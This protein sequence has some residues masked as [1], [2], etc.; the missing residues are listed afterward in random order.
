MSATLGQYGMNRSIAE[1]E[2]SR[3]QLRSPKYRTRDVES[4]RVVGPLGLLLVAC[5]A[6][7]STA[8]SPIQR[9]TQLQDSPSPSHVD[10]TPATAAPRDLSA[11]RQQLA[12]DIQRIEQQLAQAGDTTLNSYESSLVGHLRYLDSVYAQHEVVN[13]QQQQVQADLQ[14][15]ADETRRFE[16]L[17]PEAMRVAN[18]LQLERLRDERD[19]AAAKLVLADAEI[20]ST[21]SLLASVRDQFE[22]TEKRRRQI[23]DALVRANEKAQQK[24][25]QQELR[26]VELR[27]RIA[28]ELLQLRLAEQELEQLER[29]LITG[30][31]Q[32]LD[33]LL[34][35]AQSIVAFREEDLNSILARLSTEESQLSQNLM[36]Q[37]Q[38]LREVER[39][40]ASQTASDAAESEE[41]ART[42]RRTIQRTIAQTNES[43][44]T[45]LVIRHVWKIRY[46]VL[47]GLASN[48]EMQQLRDEA[49]RYLG[50]IQDEVNVL[51][52]ETQETRIE[53]DTKSRA[54]SDTGMG[55]TAD[56]PGQVISD[57]FRI[58]GRRQRL[59]RTGERLLNRLQQD[60]TA[61]LGE[62]DDRSTYAI[63]LPTLRGWWTY[64]L[65]AVDDRPITI[66]KLC[67]A[68]LSLG[69]GI[70]LSRHVSRVV[71]NRML[72]RL[73]I[74]Q[75]ASLAAQTIVFY[76]MIV[77][78]GLFTLE[79]LNI[80]ITIL[81]F[82]GGAAAIAVGFGSQN[83]LNNFISGL[84]IL[85]EQPIRVGD[86][87]AVDGLHGIV[88]R[89]GGRSTRVRTGA[90]FEIIIPNSK[91][92][93]NNV[94]N[95]TLSS[96][97]T[98]TSVSVGVA[99]GT[100]VE[101]VIRLLRQAVDDATFVLKRPEPI[102]LFTDF[103]DNA[104]QFEVHFWIYQRTL[105]DR[106]R[107]DSAIRQ[108]IDRLFREHR[109]SIAFPQRDVHVD[110]SAPLDI[111]LVAPQ[112]QDVRLDRRNAA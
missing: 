57:W 88:E 71:G 103:G 53:S 109:I 16:L 52:S 104:L 93:E 18:F 54:S 37:Q 95:L 42:I 2:P 64:E 5:L 106:Q 22:S 90:N 49:E 55:R 99:Y 23:E 39:W 68:L 27:G 101:L 10:P 79:L 84:I 98:R 26:V 67:S 46:R 56:L 35:A 89:I 13:E 65:L 25:L 108:Q 44:S 96:W 19:N 78:I 66:G 91:F 82:F 105:M 102:V 48:E 1:S 70:L 94:T 14:Q 83:I 80:P 81:T 21:A 15:L 30:R 43:L 110:L 32:H 8:Q 28:E 40:H 92:L 61:R 24:K 20:K 34:P 76:S 60:L 12:V 97:E 33:Q 75:G 112:D 69:F 74:H 31:I 77:L 73:G 47:S 29:R 62:R 86:L 6:S 36:R 100:D 51:N 59:L 7:P 50:R 87:I 4:R 9:L 58:A 63:V 41:Q 107:A 45:V 3:A 72:P 38:M 17:G 85:G 111:R 11:L